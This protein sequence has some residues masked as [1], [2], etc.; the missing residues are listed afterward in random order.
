[1]TA[2]RRLKV[3][4][5][6][7]ISLAALMLSNP[8][9]AEPKGKNGEACNVESKTNVDHTINGKKYKCD[10]CVYSK[11][12]TGGGTVSNCQN[13]TYWSNCVEA[14]SFGAG[15]AGPTVKSGGVMAP[16][17]NRSKSHKLPNMNGPGPKS[18]Q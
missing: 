9:G 1:M 8:A 14:A 4:S 16:P 12:D 11:C 13:I 6:V 3:P 15:N 18:M 5:S 17:D 7:A 2:S 10:K